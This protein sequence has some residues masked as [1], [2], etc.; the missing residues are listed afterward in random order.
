M[1]CEKCKRNEA[2][3]HISKNINGRAIE[4]HLCESC[5]QES[6]ELLSIN[7]IFGGFFESVLPFKARRVA[8]MPVSNQADNKY[9][10][11]EDCIEDLPAY[12]PPETSSST[13]QKLKTENEQTAN[14]D[15]ALILLRLELKDAVQKEEFE[16][17]AKI[18]DEIKKL[19]G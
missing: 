11:C 13:E 19:E 8:C 9:A 3:V 6:G 12:K 18:R 7:Q 16:N 4:L 1:L 2:N 17:A 10:G 14:N 5:A 15:A